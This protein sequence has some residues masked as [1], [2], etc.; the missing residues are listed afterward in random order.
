[1]RPLLLVALCLTTIACSDR[2]KPPPE[3]V[4]VSEEGTDLPRRAASMAPSLYDEHG[5]LKMSDVKVVG[6]VLPEGTD[7]VGEQG[8]RH[9]LVSRAP[10]DKLKDFF[11]KQ[12]DTGSLVERGPTVVFERAQLK[13]GGGGAALL[14][15]S[16][17]PAGRDRSRIEIREIP[18]P[19]A[20]EKQVSPQ[21][22]IRRME[23]AQRYLD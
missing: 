6:L 16:L 21:E 3:H 4:P 7:L 9:S 1:M 12:L 15:V 18:P 2:E 17:M 10:V 8:R 23:E 22:A 20:V 14:S 5:N 19:R 11:A 13:R